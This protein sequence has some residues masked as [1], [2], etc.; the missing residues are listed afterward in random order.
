M[1]DKSFELENFQKS[2]NHKFEEVKM[3]LKDP[4][5]SKAKD[6]RQK[7]EKKF[8]ELYEGRTVEK[9]ILIENGLKSSKLQN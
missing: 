2:F 4:K 8:L 7:L 5:K 6:T 1:N 3:L 9:Q